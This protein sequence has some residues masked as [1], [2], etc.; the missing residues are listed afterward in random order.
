MKLPLEAILVDNGIGFLV[1]VLATGYGLGWIV[2]ESQ[3]DAGEQQRPSS[4]R[5]F[6]L[7]AGPFMIVALFVKFLADFLQHQ[8][9]P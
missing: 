1:G 8:P 3:P 4:F 7:W 2:P 5:R 6:F 9:A